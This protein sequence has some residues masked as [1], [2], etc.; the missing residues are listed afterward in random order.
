MKC[1]HCGGELLL[2][3]RFFKPM[4]ISDPK[5]MTGAERVAKHR[6]KLELLRNG[7]GIPRDPLYRPYEQLKGLDG[8]LTELEEA[9]KE[10]NR[11][12]RELK[13]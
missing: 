2:D 13:K 10:V 12:Y 1:P 8:K 4:E 6:L 11:L 5:P 9:M 3:I 7:L